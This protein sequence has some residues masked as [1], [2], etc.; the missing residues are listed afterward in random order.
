M[1]S[2][3]LS[4]DHIKTTVIR[5]HRRKIILRRAKKRVTPA[6]KEPNDRTTHFRGDD[7]EIFSWKFLA[8]SCRPY[9]R[10]L[11]RYFPRG[12]EVL[13]VLVEHFFSVL[14]DYRHIVLEN[15]ENMKVILRPL[16][17]LQVTIAV[18]LR[19]QPILVFGRAHVE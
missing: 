8:Q 5:E 19:A 4:D 1:R 9:A 16:V 17:P 7:D 2:P 14:L 15:V 13:M 3:F 6:A 11:F 18:S 12:E 10:Q